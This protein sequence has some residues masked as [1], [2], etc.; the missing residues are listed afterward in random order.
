MCVCVSACVCV[1]VSGMHKVGTRIL[2]FLNSMYDFLFFF[3]SQK[4]LSRDPEA[5]FYFLADFS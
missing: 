1:F 3:L 2:H 4:I 5:A